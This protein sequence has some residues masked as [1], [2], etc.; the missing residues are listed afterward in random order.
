MKNL[1]QFMLL[2]MTI[3]LVSLTSCSKDDDGGGDGGAGEGT[4]T[5]KVDGQQFTSMEITSTANTVSGGGQ[6]SMTVQGNTAT[7]A[8]NLIIFGYDGVGTYELTSG[9]VFISASY[10]EPNVNDPLNMPTWSA[11]Y[12]DSGVIGQ[13]K[14][15]EDANGRVKGTFSFTGKNVETGGTKQI[16]EG[17]FNLTK[18]EN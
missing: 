18:T 8:I 17:A 11:P 10:S 12:Q 4:I 7:Q 5:A 2:V 13:I 6:T 1:K 3:S 16:T 9:N 14:I 15:S